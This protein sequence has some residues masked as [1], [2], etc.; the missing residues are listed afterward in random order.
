MGTEITIPLPLGGLMEEASTAEVSGMYAGE[1][2]NWSSTGAS[3]QTRLQHSTTA[4]TTSGILQRMPY[5]FNGSNSLIEVSASQVQV[6]ATTAT[7]T[8][9]QAFS[10]GHIS[11]NAI[12]ADG[13]GPPLLWNG[14]TFSD[15]VFT[16]STG[17]DP[18]TFDG[19]LAHQDRAF[20]W[21][22][23]DALDF[24]YSDTVGAITGN[25]NQFPLGRLGNIT[26][27]IL[28]LYSLTVDAGHGLNDTLAVFTDTGDIVVYEGLDPADSLDWR[29]QSR[30]RIAPPVS[31]EA[32][33]KIGGDVWI[34]TASGLVS[35]LATLQSGATALVNTVSDAIQDTLVAQ[36]AEGGE[37]SIH[38]SADAR[39]VIINRVYN[40]AASQFIYNTKSKGWEASDYPA[41]RWHNLG[42]Q[43]QFTAIN[44][45]LGTLDANGTV[46]I[47]ATWV[48][49]WFRL[50][51]RTAI[52]YVRPTIYSTGDLTVKMTV[53]S[54][55][56]ET[57]TD[58]AEAEQTVTL[59]PDETGTRVTMNEV[60]A[61][62]AVGDVFQL[63]MEVTSTWAE[64]VNVKAGVA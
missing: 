44:G 45:D 9:S 38:R 23:G 49:S 57:A 48:S 21:R 20:F 15:G 3:L 54:D 62:D 31:C 4:G 53:L 12:M 29:Q 33:E 64:I 47:T 25:L 63:R 5:E 27:T 2:L 60:I 30:L 35:V 42:L 61:C 19:F 13:N 56:D 36:V 18:N 1:L 6:G 32:I 26:G 10:F 22:T 8:F 17:F 43:T 50:P 51:K 55:H 11:G 14:T 41:R 40:G 39:R 59:V 37:W 34:L 16:T 58:I 28:C 7:R 46:S 24:Y 52:N